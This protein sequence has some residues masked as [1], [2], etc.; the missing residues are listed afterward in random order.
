MHKIKAINNATFCRLFIYFKMPY[1]MCF[2]LSVNIDFLFKVKLY[3]QQGT[4]NTA[5]SF[6]EMKFKYLFTFTITMKNS[7]ANLKNQFMRPQPDNAIISSYRIYETLSWHTAI[8]NAFPS[9][10]HAKAIGNSRF[11]IVAH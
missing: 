9:M 6:S 7:D 4:L 5:S 8:L 11:W 10:R 1:S 3:W 2:S